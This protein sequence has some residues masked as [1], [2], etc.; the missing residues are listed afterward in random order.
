MGTAVGVEADVGVGGE[1]AGVLEGG[2][3]ALGR[4]ISLIFMLKCWK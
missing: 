4:L 1:E 3:E 2:E